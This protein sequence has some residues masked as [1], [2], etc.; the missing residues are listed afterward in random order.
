MILENSTA[1]RLPAAR[2][3]T[4]PVRVKATFIALLPS[5]WFSTSSYRSSGNVTAKRAASPDGRKTVLVAAAILAVIMGQL[6]NGLASFVTVL[7]AKFGWSRGDISLIN[8]FGLIGLAAGGIVMGLVADRIGSRRVVIVGV[9]VSAVSFA[10]ASF[11]GTLPQFYTIYFFA[12]LFGGG[13]VFGPLIALTGRSFAAGAGLALGLVAAGQALG[14]GLVPVVNVVLIETLGWRGALQ[15]FGLG[16]AALLLPLAMTLKEPQGTM[17][18][19]GQPDAAAPLPTGF[20]VT[21]MAIAVFWCCTLMSIPLMHLLPLMEF[22]GIGSSEAGGTVFV[23]MVAAIVGRI[24]FGKLADMIGPVEAWLAA[25]AWQTVLVFGFAQIDAL[26]LFLVFAPIYGFGYAGV[27]TAVLAT[28]KAL[29]PV[30]RRASM[31]GI[32]LASAWI[33]HA[34]GGFAG[35]ALFDLTLDYRAAFGFAM[36]AG[37]I[38]LA[39]V[40]SIWLALKGA[41][42]AVAA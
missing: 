19:V 23:M 25:S 33:G 32:I 36:G 29:T 10:L 9:C 26:G 40:G 27:M 21:M 17:V 4:I 42:P 3:R 38:N 1:V 11:A 12:G 18:S 16:S 30:T 35:G 22:C 37:L 41:R 5:S 8:S 13:A 14:Q 39:V 7:E 34:F 20:A 24:A 6:V 15:A 2:R 28:S 31:T